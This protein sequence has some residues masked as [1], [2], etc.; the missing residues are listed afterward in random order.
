[1]DW[2]QIFVPVLII[3]AVGVFVGSRIW[4]LFKK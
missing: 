4:I 3:I 1:M 2:G